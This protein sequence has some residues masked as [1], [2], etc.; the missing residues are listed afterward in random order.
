MESFYI[1]EKKTHTQQRAHFVMNLGITNLKCHCYKRLT[2]L[3]NVCPDL[4]SQQTKHHSIPNKLMYAIG[5]LLMYITD[6]V[7]INHKEHCQHCKKRYS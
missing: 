3:G 6:N 4:I 5:K 1:I 7:I 2:L